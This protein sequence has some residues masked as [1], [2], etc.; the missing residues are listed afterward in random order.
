VTDPASGDEPPKCLGGCGRSLW[1]PV[2]VARG[3]GRRC[4]EKRHGPPGRPARI[5]TTS[6]TEQMPGQAELELQPVQVS[7]WSL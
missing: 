3:W 4:W 7:L 6:S 5:R 1:D 2:S